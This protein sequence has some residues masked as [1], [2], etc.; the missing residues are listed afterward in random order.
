MEESIQEVY[1]KR[2]I[3][4][5]EEHS[6]RDYSIFPGGCRHYISEKYC[7]VCQSV[8]LLLIFKHYEH[9]NNQLSDDRENSSLEVLGNIPLD[10]KRLIC[11]TVK[12]ERE[13]ERRIREEKLHIQ[14]MIQMA[15]EFKRQKKE[16]EAVTKFLY[17]TVAE[18]LFT[19]KDMPI[20]EDFTV[21][22]I[23]FGYSMISMEKAIDIVA[24]YK[25]GSRRFG[26]VYRPTTQV[27][28]RDERRLSHNATL[29]TL[30]S[31]GF[32]LIPRMQFL[33]AT[34]INETPLDFN[35]LYPG[36]NVVP[37]EERLRLSVIKR[38]LGMRTLSKI[39]N[40]SNLLPSQDDMIS[41]PSAY[42]LPLSFDYPSLYPSHISTTD[43]DSQID[44]ILKTLDWCRHCHDKISCEKCVQE[45]IEAMMF[46]FSLHEKNKTRI[47]GRIPRDIKKLLCFTIRQEHEQ[48]QINSDPLSV[49]FRTANTLKKILDRVN[50]IT[51]KLSK[52][53][54]VLRMV[55]RGDIDKITHI[56][57]SK[58]SCMKSDKPSNMFRISNDFYEHM[59]NASESQRFIFL[60]A[61][62]IN[63]T[64]REIPILDFNQ[65]Y[66]SLNI[67]REEEVLRQQ[68]IRQARI[69]IANQ[70]L[71]NASK[72]KLARLAKMQARMRRN[73]M[74]RVLKIH[75]QLSDSKKS[76]I[77][78]LR[79][80]SR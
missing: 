2:V 76:R 26:N 73:S 45:S 1:A 57:L 66:P 74:R 8:V 38:A 48:R 17:D 79:W 33:S 25:K 53:E 40:T 36:I 11:S 6:R 63:R 15:E 50:T 60:S 67:V 61:T 65:L 49:F 5:D 54:Q 43:R 68:V 27:M 12:K 32:S 30:R 58:E 64:P 18:I 46:A 37:A 29:L 56:D 16:Q 28:F 42:T 35:N 51:N 14:L 19:S 72:G 20:P 55:N 69:S 44:D 41:F 39:A 13:N 7:G 22:S 80:K 3:V 4:K 62:D 70:L 23:P 71:A 78:V 75:K 10:I 24:A 52:Y 31:K 21:A 9:D 77:K 34:D 47:V 59:R